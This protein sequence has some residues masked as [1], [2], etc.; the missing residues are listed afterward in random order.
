MCL[1]SKKFRNKYL[2]TI[3]FFEQQSIYI[4][5]WFSGL[6]QMVSKVIHPHNR[7]LVLRAVHVDI[8]FFSSHIKLASFS[9]IVAKEGELVECAKKN[10]SAISNVQQKTVEEPLIG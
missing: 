2:I 9:P 10:C 7:Q 1:I 4:F 6:D 8:A 5:R 3:G